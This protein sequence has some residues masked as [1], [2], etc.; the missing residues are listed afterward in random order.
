MLVEKENKKRHTFGNISS[1]FGIATS[2]YYGPH[3]KG[4]KIEKSDCWYH[5]PGPIGY[6]TLNDDNLIFRS[7]VAVLLKYCTN[8]EVIV[9]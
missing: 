4:N 2:Y 9:G 5:H 7:C 3:S 1:A 6:Q 8:L